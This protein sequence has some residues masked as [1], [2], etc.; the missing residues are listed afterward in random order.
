MEQKYT[1]YIH[2]TPNGKMYVGQSKNIEKR[3]KQGYGTNKEFYTDITKYGWNNIEHI[4]VATNLD[5]G[6][7]NTL[8]HNLIM[9]YKT[10]DD[11]FGYNRTFGKT[12][13]GKNYYGKI[14]N[15]YRALWRMR[16]KG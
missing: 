13:D 1:V 2:K 5:K 16:R 9:K 4:I 12:A 10:Y 7:A 11:E 6:E 3:W 8:E 15:M 14:E